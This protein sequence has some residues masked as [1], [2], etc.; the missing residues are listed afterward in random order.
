MSYRL[1][2]LLTKKRVVN[3]NGISHQGYCSQMQRICLKSHIIST[4][5]NFKEYA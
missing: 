5:N 1:V 4:V 2:A 3:K